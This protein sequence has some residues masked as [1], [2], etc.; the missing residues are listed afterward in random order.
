[1][2]GI[3]EVLVNMGC[4]VSGSDQSESAQTLHLKD[5]GVHITIGHD[6]SNLPEQCHVV[7]FSSAVN[8]KNPELIAAREKNIPVIQRAEMLAELMGL[9]RSIAIGGTHGKTTTTSLVATM[10]I[11]SGLDPTVVVGGRLDLIKSSAKLGQG[12]W[13]VAEADESDGSFLRLAPEMAVITNI[14]DDHLD[15]F[16]SMD[17][18]RKAFRQ[19]AEHIPFYGCTVLCAD[20]PLVLKLTEGLSKRKLL[21]G[22]TGRAEL[23]GENLKVE[24]GFQKF[25]VTF[26]GKLLGEIELRVPGRH[27][28]LNALAAVGVGLELGMDFEAIRSGLKSYGGVDR[29]LQ[30]IGE[31]NHVEIFDDYGHHPTE[32]KATLGALKE[33]HPEKR[34]VVAFQPHRYTRTQKCW[35]EFQT[36]F[37]DAD[38]IGF[39][40]IYAAS[41]KKIPRITSAALAKATQN[42]N[43][44]KS[45]FYWGS[46]KTVSKFLQ[47]NLKAGDLFLTLGA[48]DVYK[49]G[50][51]YLKS[52]G[53][54]E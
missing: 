2:S 31:V 26:K 33:M 30:K 49:L 48:G 23:R 35:K 36:C 12:E 9:K 22:I 21:Y 51:E 52:H 3:A 7:V 14:D 8:P 17:N 27:N 50:I 24:N 44:R 19:F 40:D 39:L 41:E 46:F 10:M 43:K 37:K 42:E 1:M 15:H 29:R 25:D 6:K 16:K 5:L 38:V 54:K 32:I 4:S 18:L 28:V 53:S 13:L 34:L 11:H 20:D 47:R 45:V